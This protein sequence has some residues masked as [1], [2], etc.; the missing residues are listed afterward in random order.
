MSV[1]K[2]RES[3][4]T[5]TDQRTLLLIFLLWVI[6]PAWAVP[7]APQP[8][9]YNE[10]R[11]PAFTPPV[12]DARLVGPGWDKQGVTYPAEFKD[13]DLLVTTDQHQHAIVTPLIASFA[14]QKGVNIVVRR[15][16]CGTSSGTLSKKEADI[17]GYCCPP[18]ASD[19]LPGLRFHTLGIMPNVVIVHRD[20]PLNGISFLQL[21]QLYLGEVRN[22]SEIAAA[23]S[24]RHPVQPVTRLHCKA[25]P[26]HWRSV[27]DNEDLFSISSYNVGAIEDMLSRVIADPSAIGYL[28]AWAIQHYDREKRAKVLRIGGA[29]P[30]DRKAVKALRYP[31]YKTLVLTTWT[32]AAANPLADELIQFL[33]Q[34]L[35]KQKTSYFIPASELKQSGWKFSGN[36]LIGEPDIVK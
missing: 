23:S 4:L 27:L 24:Y 30:H 10:L 34:Q 6:S 3:Q 1:I 5:T 28:S 22:W 32:D 11:G 36:E 14:K 35:K 13:I 31:F 16:T 15:G 21:Q 26:G 20:N 12:E 8:N 33:L 25:R 18:G 19:R 7:P 2:Q 9:A 17:G 29:D